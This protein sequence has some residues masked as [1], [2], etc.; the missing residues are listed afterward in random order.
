MAISEL[1]ASHHQRKKCI[2]RFLSSD[3]FALISAQCALIP[4]MRQMA[5]I[6]GLTPVMID[7]SDLG[8]KRS[9][10]FAVV[11]FS[12][13]WQL[14][15]FGRGSL[16]RFLRQMPQHMGRRVDYVVRVKGSVHIQTGD[17]YRGALLKY[18]LR[19]IRYVLLPGVRYCSDA[20]AVV[21]LPLC[22][23]KGHKELWYLATSLGDA[24]LAV[25]KYRQ[26]MQL[27]QYLALDSATVTTR[28][29]LLVGLALGCGV[30]LLLAGR[31]VLW[32]F[33]RR[34]CLW[35]RLGLLRLGI[36]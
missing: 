3:N 35:G 11:C 22:W 8:R 10:L 5:G 32:Q 27:E 17:G 33:R 30:L 9:G 13:Y 21:N 6:K 34:V 36:E 1:P 23:G 7:W 18:P 14:G 15:G 20:A 25:D 31:R 16:L 24:K 12:C 28:S 2:R 4:A 19:K 29:R 26:R